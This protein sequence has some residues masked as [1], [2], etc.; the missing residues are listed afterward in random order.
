M[1]IRNWPIV[2]G[3]DVAGEVH[4]VGSNVTRFKIGD[5]VVA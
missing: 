5:R 1:F 2:L 4:A 3:L